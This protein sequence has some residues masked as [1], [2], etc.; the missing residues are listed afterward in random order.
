MK[1]YQANI[2]SFHRIS[3]NVCLLQIERN[4]SCDIVNIGFYF[5]NHLSTLNQHLQRWFWRILIFNWLTFWS[6]CYVY[7]DKIVIL[8]KYHNLHYV[9]WSMFNKVKFLNETRKVKHST[10]YLLI[11]TF[12][13]S[14]QDICDIFISYL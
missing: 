10:C 13:F 5:A 14:Q 4:I 12:I 3:P 7:D 2:L 6:S 1:F 11:I 9:K 8:N